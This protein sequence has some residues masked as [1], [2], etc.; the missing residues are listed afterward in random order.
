VAGADSAAA[1][2]PVAAAQAE[3]GNV[4]S[5]SEFQIPYWFSNLESGIWNLESGIYETSI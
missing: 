5:N 1:V 4:I 2:M 3:V